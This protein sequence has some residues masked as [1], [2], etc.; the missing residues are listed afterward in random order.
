MKVEPSKM[1]GGGAGNG[2]FA[3]E[4]I[5]A[6]SLIVEYVGEVIDT[7]EYRERTEGSGDHHR[8][9]MLQVEAGTYIDS[10]LYGNQ[11][12]FINHSCDANCKRI[13][14]GEGAGVRVGFVAARHIQ[15]GEELSI[16][17]GHSYVHQDGFV[18][19]CGAS[20]CRQAGPAATT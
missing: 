3:G 15:A 16:D 12:R 7:E 19:L 11:S 10:T 5:R 4:D 13:V 20:T 6:G 1:G 9:F 17:Y 14:A 2:L 8:A 18:C